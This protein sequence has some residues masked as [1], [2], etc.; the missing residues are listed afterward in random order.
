MEDEASLFSGHFSPHCGLPDTSDAASVATSVNTA[1]AVHEVVL[2]LHDEALHQLDQIAVVYGIDG[3]N[4]HRRSVALQIALDHF[5]NTADHSESAL[6]KSL[7]LS[8][9]PMKS[10]PVFMFANTLE[11]IGKLEKELH[12]SEIILIET[13]IRNAAETD[14]PDPAAP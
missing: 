8:S 4:E 3:M 12:C 6:L 10:R 14:A 7:R 5:K 1:A 13:A 11:E 9:G 2:P